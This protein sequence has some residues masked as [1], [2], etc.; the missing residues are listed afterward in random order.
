M[1]I[2]QWLVVLWLCLW[3]LQ[4][5]GVWM[6]M[7]TYAQLTNELMREFADG[8]IGTGTSPRRL[9][10]GSVAIIVVSADM[11]VRRV[12]VMS[13]ITFMA[14]FKPFNELENMSILTMLGTVKD[15]KYPSSLRPAMEKAHEQI[16]RAAARKEAV[17]SNDHDGILVPHALT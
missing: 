4:S 3:A 13:G 1:P 14:R 8:Y 15:S 17:Q 2:W 16:M 9:G 12:V 7:R 5:A 10:R 6:Q 11:M